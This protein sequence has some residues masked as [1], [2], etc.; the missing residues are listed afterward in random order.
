MKNQEKLKCKECG[1]NKVNIQYGLDERYPDDY[2]ID[3]MDCENWEDGN[4]TIG[5]FIV[6]GE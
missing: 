4:G 2:S 3:C 5:S 6:Q 1:S